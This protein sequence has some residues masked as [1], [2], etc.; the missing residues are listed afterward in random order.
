LWQAAA[1]QLRS[2]ICCWISLKVPAGAPGSPPSVTGLPAPAQ[3]TPVRAKIPRKT[4]ESKRNPI[5]MML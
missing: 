1:V 2:K 3:A 5:P 4:R